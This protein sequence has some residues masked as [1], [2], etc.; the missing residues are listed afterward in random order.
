MKGA[1]PRQVGKKMFSNLLNHQSRSQMSPLLQVQ[2]LASRAAQ[3]GE[4][5]LKSRGCYK[6]QEELE[7]IRECYKKWE[8]EQDESIPVD[9]PAVGIL[10]GH[11]PHIHHHHPHHREQPAVGFL[12]ILILIY[13]PLFIIIVIDIISD[14]LISNILMLKVVTRLARGAASSAAI[15]P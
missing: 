10:A 14:L 3:L 2:A 4:R 7:G 8:E 13:C 15:K 9:Q 6:R 12:F 11:Y 1:P 5:W